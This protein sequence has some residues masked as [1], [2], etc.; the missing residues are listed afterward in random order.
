VPGIETGFPISPALNFS[1][2]I[3]IERLSSVFCVKGSAT[4]LDSAV[5]RKLLLLSLMS[6]LYLP[7]GIT[8]V[9]PAARMMTTIISVIAVGRVNFF[10]I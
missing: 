7:D 6:L 8:H 1:N 4:T 9:V 2:G 3:F 10:L 5:T